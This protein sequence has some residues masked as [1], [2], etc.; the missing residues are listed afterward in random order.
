MIQT[1][2]P[3][4]KGT[5]VSRPVLKGQRLSNPQSGGDGAM[6]MAGRA[7]AAG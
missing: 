7:L 5:I 4:S 6:E 1:L 2:V 3:P